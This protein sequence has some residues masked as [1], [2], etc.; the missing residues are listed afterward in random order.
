MRKAEL[1]VQTLDACLMRI[2][3]ADGEKADQ[4]SWELREKIARIEAAVEKLKAM[5]IT[6][7]SEYMAAL[8]LF[9][10]IKEDLEPTLTLIIGIELSLRLYNATKKP[11]DQEMTIADALIMAMKD[12]RI[13]RVYTRTLD[14]SDATSVLIR[15]ERS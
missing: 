14:E 7:D 12:N 6:N 4:T 8:Q 11:Q 15:V 2:E 3:G 9:G 10:T 1:A 13:S 5:P